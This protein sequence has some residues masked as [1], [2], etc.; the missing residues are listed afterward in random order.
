MGEA[1][2]FYYLYGIAAADLAGQAGRAGQAGVAALPA[3][4]GFSSDIGPV[5]VVT[6]SDLV[7][8]VSPTDELGPDPSAANTLA[9]HQVL[10]AAM[11]AGPVIPFAFGYVLPVGMIDQLLRTTREECLQLLPTLAGKLEVGLR[12]TWA[13]EH[14]L[15]DVQ[16]PEM[17]A[18]HQE[19]AAARGPAKS[20]LEVRLGEL[21]HAA[22]EARRNEYRQ[23][24]FEPL[25]ARAVSARWLDPSGPR[26]ALN[27]A[28]LID[29]EAEAE[30][31][32]LVN[33]LCQ[34]LAPRLD[35]RYTGPWPP[36]NFVTLRVR[37]EGGD[38]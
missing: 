36:Y 32:A 34:P 14:F 24:V 1:E 21:V 33:Q 4:A 28:F 6:G 16:T 22:V 38:A 20:M 10:A 9:H 8:I 17:T 29:R 25:A 15:A 11:A 31:D 23:Q 30:F 37:L 35:V 2:P 13:K 18:A 19:L 5:S 7:A 3:L 27:A 26:T 12:L